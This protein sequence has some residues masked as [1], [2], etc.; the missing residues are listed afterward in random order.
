MGSGART[1]VAPLEDG[2]PSE[3]LGLRL[4]QPVVEPATGDAGTRRG[5]AF[6]GP[7]AGAVAAQPPGCDRPAEPQRAQPHARRPAGPAP[8]SRPSPAPRTGTHVRRHAPCPQ[9]RR[10]RRPA[11]EPPPRPQA[12]PGER[13]VRA[14]P[15]RGQHVVPRRHDA[16]AADDLGLRRLDRRPARLRLPA[17]PAAPARARS[18]RPP[19]SPR[20]PA[21]P[22]PAEARRHMA[23]RRP[24][25]RRQVASRQVAL[26]AVRRTAGRTPSERHNGIGRRRRSRYTSRPSRGCSSVGRA[27]QSHC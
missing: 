1:A 7:P 6:D 9:P 19:P 25:P 24:Q 13:A 2:E 4:P 11:G 12:A 22:V 21:R 17:R 26:P 14:R 27:Q 16:V 20:P 8:A 5:D 18:C 3:L 23:D 15:H 10:A